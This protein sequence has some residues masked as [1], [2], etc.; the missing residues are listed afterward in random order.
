[1]KGG[2]LLMTF[3]A[4]SSSAKVGLFDIEGDH[5]RPIAKGAIDFRAAPVR[6]HLTQ[7]HSTQDAALKS[8]ASDDLREV[9]TEA[10]EWLAK[11][12][13][14]NRIGLVGHRVV[15]GGDKF[16]GPVALND[17][18]IEAIEALTF[19]A[20]L[21]QPHSVR[22]IKAIR[23]MRPEL[24]QTA[25]FDTAFHR[26]N[27]DIVQR[28]AIPRKFHDDGVKRYGFHG[29]SYKFISS[30]LWQSTPDLA[31]G[32]VIVAHLGSGA[33]LCAMEG[34]ISRDTSMGF[35]TLD[36]IPMATRCGALDPG[37][38]FHLLGPMEYT[39]HEV[40]D[41]LYHQ[42]G[43][44]GV[45]GFS[46]DSRELLASAEPEA[47]EALDL[48]AFRTAG[49]IARLVA[50]LGGMDALVFTAGIGEHQPPIRA[51][52]C[53]RLAWLGLELDTRANESNAET[54]SAGSSRAR[55]LIIPTDEE[56]VI[57]DEAVATYR[58]VQGGKSFAA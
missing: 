1:M 21:H 5:A 46:A 17:A 8:K 13:D 11:H 36:G 48:F 43:L 28:F 29:L 58:A 55:V 27:R 37:V 7:G 4:G 49:E 54:I 15:H 9:L 32:K 38:L 33:S 6:F 41:I 2:H 14:V 42:S 45:S 19:L 24:M 10:F 56:Q 26:T 12:F 34:G 57:A 31:K 53:G 50:T 25:S 18:A 16:C 47:R 3:N 51:A 22:V 40:E 23:Q 30:Q 20:P 35:S 52:I 44:M 39:L